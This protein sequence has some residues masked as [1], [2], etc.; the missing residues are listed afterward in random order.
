M[1]LLSLNK[2][3]CE[4]CIG[5]LIESPRTEATHWGQRVLFSVVFT[6][7]PPSHHGSVWVLPVLSVLLTNTVSPV[8]AY[9]HMM[10]EVS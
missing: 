8:L 2:H 3:L 4:H 9:D 7:S 1:I 10:G 6:P 5:T